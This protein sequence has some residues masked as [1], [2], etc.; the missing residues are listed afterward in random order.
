MYFFAKVFLV[1]Q[2][3]YLI[4]VLG[5]STSSSSQLPPTTTSPTASECSS[6][7][8]APVT[9]PLSNGLALTP[10]M[11]W[12]SWNQFGDLIDETLIKSTID[13]MIS[14]GLK[15]AGFIYV[16]L[17][18]GWQRY[19]GNRS[20]HPL[21]VD[22]VK[23]PNGMKALADYAH[24]KGFKLGIYSGPGDITV[25]TTRSLNSLFLVSNPVLQS[26]GPLFQSIIRLFL[27]SDTTLNR[28]YTSKSFS[29]REY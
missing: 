5:L 6:G 23:F 25:T 7:L 28:R 27:L 15:D 29:R 14:N 13:A 26:L 22:P 17:D 16:N 3:T 11:G 19:K 1:V 2:T 18:D 8:E 21:E 20:N 10:P 12:S 4:V 9:S 24:D